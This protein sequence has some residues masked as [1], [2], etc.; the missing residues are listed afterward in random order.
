MA[1]SCFMIPVSVRRIFPSPARSSLSKSTGTWI[2]SL[3]DSG[4]TIV[5]STCADV[6]RGRG[7]AGWLDRRMH[8]E[9]LVGATVVLRPLREDDVPTIV[10]ACRDADMVRWTSIPHP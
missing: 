2:G 9:R 5:R 4:R 7:G 8:P 10:V 3:M 1:L 6:G